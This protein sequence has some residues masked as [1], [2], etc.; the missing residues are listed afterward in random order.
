MNDDKLKL[1]IQ[2]LADKNKSQKNIEIDLIKIKTQ[3]EKD[4]R[5]KIKIGAELNDKSMK[6]ALSKAE[7]DLARW[8]DVGIFR[9]NKLSSNFEQFLNENNKISK[10]SKEVENLRATISNINDNTSLRKATAQVSAFK[11][12]MTTLGRTGKSV[13][14]Q[15]SN[16]FLKFG[17]WL[18]VG[19]ILVQSINLTKKLIENVIEL[20]GAMTNIRYVTGDNYESTMMLVD[21]YEKLAQRLGTTTQEVLISSNEWLN[22]IGRLYRNI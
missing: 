12:E 18:G 17:T 2:I 13:A 1:A 4:P 7:R 20:D 19:S 3:I 5:L 8:N 10:T 16:A 14:S 6:Q 15:L 21:S 11:S 22:K 9:K